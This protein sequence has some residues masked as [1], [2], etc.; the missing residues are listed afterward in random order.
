MHMFVDCKVNLYIRSRNTYSI[1]ILLLSV[2]SLEFKIGLGASR[3]L[4]TQRTETHRQTDR[5]TDI[6][7]Q[8]TKT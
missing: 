4:W 5:Q 7:Q 6:L 8:K 3:L 1:L 2:R